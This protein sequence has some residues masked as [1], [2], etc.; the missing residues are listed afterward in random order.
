MAWRQYTKSRQKPRPQR[1]GRPKTGQD[2]M[3][4][5]AAVSDTVLE[6][7]GREPEPK[8]LEIQLSRL[9]DIRHIIELANNGR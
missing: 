8:R 7:T 9:Y 3:R 6:R 1:M 5:Y 2:M 4:Y